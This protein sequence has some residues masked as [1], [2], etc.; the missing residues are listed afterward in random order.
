MADVNINYKGSTLTE[1]ND[2]GTKTL[3]TSGTYCED[4][5][6]VVYTKPIAAVTSKYF[7]VTV[8]TKVSGSWQT[9]VNAD[10]DIAAHCND[11]SF[12]FA[13]HCLSAPSKAVSVRGGLY[14][15]SPLSYYD[16]AHTRPYY[17]F[18]TRTNS[19]SVGAAAMLENKPTVET[20]AQGAAFVNTDG[21]IKIYGSSA[22]PILAGT[23]QISVWW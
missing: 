12:G 15:N 11:D 18:Y 6:S 9:L 20:A 2:S 4:D 3:K 19:S 22:Y 8:S 13:W 10:S 1:M 21:S 14:S 5:I 23:Y 16:S 7:D 17:G